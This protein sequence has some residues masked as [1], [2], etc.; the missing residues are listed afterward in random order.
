MDDD[1]YK[2]AIL[3]VCT[4][5]ERPP[6][7]E[8]PLPEFDLGE[9]QV[10]PHC[11]G[12]DSLVSE[13]EDGEVANCPDC[14]TMFTPKMESLSRQVIRKLSERRARRLREVAV[15]ERLSP[16][17]PKGVDPDD[18]AAFRVAVDSAN[19]EEEPVLEPPI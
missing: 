9:A 10:C 12:L 1:R 2:A 13:S 19:V 18:Y 8:A 5:V 7:Q 16:T 3:R 14:Q 15:Y 11:G 6:L 17:P 4:P